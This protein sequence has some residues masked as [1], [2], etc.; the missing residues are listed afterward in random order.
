MSAKTI[1]IREK[2]PLKGTWTHL[3]VL[4]GG[5]ARSEEYM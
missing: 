5:Y 2:K 4:R 3:E 1:Q